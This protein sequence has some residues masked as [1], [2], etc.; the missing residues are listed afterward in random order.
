M[1]DLAA[2]LYETVRQYAAIGAHHRTGTAEDAC[3][4]DWFEDRVRALGATTERQ[5]WS[6]DRYD[7]EWR[8][9]VDGVEV[10][11]LPLFYEGTGEID[12][13]APV[14]AVVDAVSAGA[15]P[16][17]PAIVAD[18]RSAGAPVAVVATR[19][20]SGGLFAPNRAPAPPGPGLPGLLVAGALAGRLPTASVRARIAARIVGGTTSNV[21]GRIGAGPDR[22]RVLLT[23]PLSGWFRCAG[24]RGTGI[25]VMLAVAERLA[26]EGVPLLVNGNS[27]H[28]L[29]DVGAHRFAETKPA[30]RAI[31]HFGASVAAGE[32]DESD[33]RLAEGVKVR[34]WVPG[35]EA[36]LTD[37]FSPLGKT[38]VFIGDADRARPESW[39][40]EGRAWCTLERPLISMAGGF[41]LFHTP[42]DV[43]EL[44]TTP[45]LLERV[46]HAALGATRLIT[47]TA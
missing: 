40:G 34:A 21:I 10:D 29:V 30:V 18:A 17:W 24:E 5:P 41:S 23:T 25:A 1:T 6:F 43:P 2:R 36:A 45:A 38:P 7:A 37:A 27:G 44:A 47:K 28:E 9:T 39:V 15:F 4:L 33:D 20:P 26:A 19:S 16:T 11:A 32:R 46:Y 8:V 35:A 14:V 3:T 22:D 13:T 31:F 12:S 42:E